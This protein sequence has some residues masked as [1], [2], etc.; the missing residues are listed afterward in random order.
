MASFCHCQTILGK[1][2]NERGRSLFHLI[3]QFSIESIIPDE[4]GYWNC[5]AGDGDIEK[6]I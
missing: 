5:C 3:G 2:E 4:N 1:R 6:A